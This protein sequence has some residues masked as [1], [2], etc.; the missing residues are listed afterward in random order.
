MHGIQG[1]DAPFDQLRRQQRLERAD[2]MLFLLHIAL[3]PDDAGGD[4]IT[5]E[6][7]NGMGLRTG[8]VKG[9]A[10]KG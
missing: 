6:L 3:P 1:E 9:F 5:T 8:G 4:L 7:M 10:I 2:L